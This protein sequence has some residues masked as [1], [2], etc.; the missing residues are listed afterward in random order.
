[1]A[2]PGFS[3]HTF[4]GPRVVTHRHF[5]LGRKSKA[6]LGLET[7]GEIPKLALS[8]VTAL[9]NQSGSLWIEDV[10]LKA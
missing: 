3:G 10:K 9:K 7:S 5:N 1:M 6:K 4:F 8:K 2:K